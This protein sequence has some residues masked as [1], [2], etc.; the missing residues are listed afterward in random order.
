[1]KIYKWLRGLMKASAL[2]TVMF[3]MQAC[4]GVPKNMEDSVEIRIC[5]YVTDKATGQPLQGI[6]LHVFHAD[7]WSGCHDFGNSDENGYFEMR[8]WGNINRVSSLTIEVEDAEENNYQP[9]DT[10]VYS[11]KDLTGLKIKLKSNQ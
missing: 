1:M 2:T 7:G 11:D 5:G 3:I 9:F 6:H 10:L 4:Y 8:Q